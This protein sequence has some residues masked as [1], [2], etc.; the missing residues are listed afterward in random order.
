VRVE[1]LLVEV[2][3]AAVIPVLPLLVVSL[4]RAFVG[5]FGASLN[6]EGSQLDGDRSSRA[7]L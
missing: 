4:V 5:R 1:A 6:N 7:R 2:L 3:A